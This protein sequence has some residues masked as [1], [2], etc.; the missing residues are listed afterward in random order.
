MQVFGLKKFR[1]N[2]LEA[3]TAIVGPTVSDTKEDQLK[4]ECY[5]AL[6]RLRLDIA[7]R[8]KLKNPEYILAS[9]SLQAM[10]R[11]LPTTKE[12]L[13]VVEGY[14]E[15][16]WNRFEGEEFL[17]ITREFSQEVAKLAKTEEGGSVT[18]GT[19]GRE[20][21]SCTSRATR[22]EVCDPLWETASIRRLGILPPNPRDQPFPY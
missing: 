22:E 17:K 8:H 3:V 15:V 12:E 11:L 21:T 9:A 5:K 2:Q 1:P 7:N 18:E 13:L 6:C 10:S 14:T 19:A 4:A 20:T 16:Q